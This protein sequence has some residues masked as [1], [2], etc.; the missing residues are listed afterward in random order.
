LAIDLSGWKIIDGSGAETILNG[1][2]GPFGNDNFLVVENPK[3]KLNNAGDAIILKDTNNNI[4]DQVYYGNW[5]TGSPEQNAPVAKDPNS[6]ARIFDGAQTFN[7]KN[8]FVITQTP[9][10]GQANIITL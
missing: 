8:D 9:T 6:T 10:K 1:T 4:I 7:N 2:L 3:G 5:D